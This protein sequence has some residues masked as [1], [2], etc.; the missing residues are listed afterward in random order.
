MTQTLFEYKND[1]LTAKNHSI[2]F[3][4]EGEPQQRG[5]KNP[6]IIR[7]KQKQMLRRG[8]GIVRTAY[9]HP[10]MVVPDSNKK[11]EP[12][13]KLVAL[14]AQE[15]WGRDPMEGAVVLEVEFHFR[16]PKCHYRTG[17]YSDQLKPRF[18]ELKYHTKKP[19]LS[20]LIRCVEDGITY[21]KI[22]EDDNQVVSYGS[23]AKYWTIGDGFALVTMTPLDSVDKDKFQETE[24][25]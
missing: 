6:Y 2:Q 15:A 11:S 1:E 12:Y 19:D 3:Q 10:I 23:T 21:G 14:R 17:K 25:G 4:I 20:K 9:D 8:G 24:K 22:W 16:R 13:M 18:A 5:S 7:N